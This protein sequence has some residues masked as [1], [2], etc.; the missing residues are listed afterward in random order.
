[1]EQSKNRTDEGR[2]KVKWCDT[3]G[4]NSIANKCL[5]FRSLEA[6]KS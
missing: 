1:M 5:G 6:L 4:I 2:R 3:V